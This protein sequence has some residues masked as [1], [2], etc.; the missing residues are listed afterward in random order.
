MGRVMRNPRGD[1]SCLFAALVRDLY[2]GQ[3]ELAV[4]SESR[5]SP[6]V[7]ILS[8]PE[9]RGARARLTPAKRTMV[10]LS[11]ARDYLAYLD[12]CYPRL[13]EHLHA[14]C[15]PDQAFLVV[16]RWVRHVDLGERLLRFGRENDLN[17]RCVDYARR[18][19]RLNGVSVVFDRASYRWRLEEGAV[20]ELLRDPRRRDRSWTSALNPRW[21]LHRAAD[22]LSLVARRAAAMV[23]S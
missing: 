17:L 6:Y 10:R 19:S 8:H 14:A 3:Y 16:E 20:D 7:Q 18:E 9:R 11:P 5:A 15:R 2:L 23:L 21:P 22:R 4:G 1:I 13:Y 12:N